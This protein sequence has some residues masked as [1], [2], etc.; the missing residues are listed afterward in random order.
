MQKVCQDI[1]KYVMT[2]YIIYIYQYYLLGDFYVSHI[3]GHMH[4]I[5][6]FGH[7]P[8]ISYITIYFY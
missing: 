5:Y 8:W 6:L 3:L 2:L 7:L 4:F 1:K